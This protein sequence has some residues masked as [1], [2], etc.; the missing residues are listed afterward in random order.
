MGNSPYLILGPLKGWAILVPLKGW[1]NLVSLKGWVNLSTF[2]NFFLFFFIIN[3]VP[4]LSVLIFCFF[5]SPL[6]PAPYF[7]YNL[8]LLGKEYKME[9][10]LVIFEKGD[11]KILFIS[12]AFLCGRFFRNK[13]YHNSI[14]LFSVQCTL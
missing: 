7:I 12:V 14:P 4:C 8:K 5:L 6:P 1:V 9:I 2:L 3:I 11:K 10:I 13:S